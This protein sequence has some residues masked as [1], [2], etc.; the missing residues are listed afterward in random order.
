MKKPLLPVSNSWIRQLMNV[1]VAKIDTPD[2]VKS[3]EPDS[4]DFGDAIKVVGIFDNFL[5]IQFEDKFY[6]CPSKIIQCFLWSFE[7]NIGGQYSE[8][9]QIL[10]CGTSGIQAIEAKLKNDMQKLYASFFSVPNN[11]SS[12]VKHLYSVVDEY[13]VSGPTDD[14]PAH[15][16][17]EEG[18]I[19]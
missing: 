3:A 1:E 17:F 5:A 7:N 9:E 16:F 4:I 8:E 18:R 10:I 14:V 13:L 12:A 6:L 2:L 15:I 19:Q 11:Q